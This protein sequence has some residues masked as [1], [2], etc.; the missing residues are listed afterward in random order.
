MISTTKTSTWS[1]KWG[2]EGFSKTEDTAICV[3][4]EEEEQLCKTGTEKHV[5]LC[6]RRKT[7]L[8]S[9]VAASLFRT[10]PYASLAKEQ[11]LD[12]KMNL[13]TSAMRAPGDNLIT[14]SK[15]KSIIYWGFPFCDRRAVTL[16]PV[17]WHETWPTKG[18]GGWGGGRLVLG[19]SL[20]GNGITHAWNPR[21]K[22][23][24]PATYQQPPTCKTCTM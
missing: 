9:E 4:T 19:M 7:L 2:W 8:S 3:R 5:D 15:L 14:C 11:D 13:N 24:R 22:H 10:D 12:N 1:T 21:S 6:Q 23:R 18:R 20:Y 16:Q 17:C